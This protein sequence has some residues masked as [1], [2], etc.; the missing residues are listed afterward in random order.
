MFLATG[1]QKAKI[2]AEAFGGLEHPTPYPCERVA[3]LN[4]RRE[5][6]IDQDAAS[7]MPKEEPENAK[8][9]A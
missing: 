5:V 8:G 2:V 3:P 9:Q 1:E 4:A 7:Q 6:L